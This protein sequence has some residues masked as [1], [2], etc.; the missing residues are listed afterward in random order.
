MR[1]G[2]RF[3]AKRCLCLQ[4]KEGVGRRMGRWKGATDLGVLEA[5]KDPTANENGPSAIAR[6]MIA[7]LK[8]CKGKI[9]SP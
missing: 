6:G 7:R 1:E 9:P 3:T 5:R 4:T 2:D 8:C